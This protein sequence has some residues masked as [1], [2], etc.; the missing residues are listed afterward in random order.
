MRDSYVVGEKVGKGKRPY[1]GFRMNFTLTS[2]DEK[3]KLSSE[4]ELGPIGVH[5]DDTVK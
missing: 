5:F 2:G 1:K 4:P 3:S